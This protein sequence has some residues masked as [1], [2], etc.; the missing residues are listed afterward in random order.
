MQKDKALRELYGKIR[1]S[2]MQ[3]FLKTVKQAEGSKILRKRDSVLQVPPAASAP[4][5]LVRVRSDT[6]VASLTSPRVR[7]VTWRSGI[8]MADWVCLFVGRK[9]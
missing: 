6:G 4:M 8:W 9:R 3:R 7:I 5:S 1:E 2:Q